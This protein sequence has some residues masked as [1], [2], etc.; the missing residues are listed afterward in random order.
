MDAEAAVDAGAGEAHEDAEFGGGL[1]VVGIRSDVGIR[2][3]GKRRVRTH[4]LRTGCAAVYADVV[5]VL[6]LDLEELLCFLVPDVVRL[7][8]VVLT[9]ALVSGST[10]HNFDMAVCGIRL[11]R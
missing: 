6:L 10:S 4:P 11:I 1:W 3:R 8:S 9:F 2:V 7:K 5:A